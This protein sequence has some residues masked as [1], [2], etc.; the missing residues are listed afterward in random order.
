[1][2]FLSSTSFRNLPLPTHR[3]TLHWRT[4]W[5][6]APQACFSHHK[7]QETADS[8]LTFPYPQSLPPPLTLAWNDFL[9]SPLSWKAWKLSTFSVPPG[10][11]GSHKTTYFYY[12][13]ISAYVTV[14]FSLV[15]CLQNG[16]LSF[17]LYVSTEY[18]KVPCAEQ[19]RSKCRIPTDYQ[20]S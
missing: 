19:G 17:Q 14:K 5:Y 15:K 13:P 11:L 18:V 8:F 9:N 4:S 3:R 6:V 20:S 12:Y 7:S 2:S 16:N 1:M 10:S